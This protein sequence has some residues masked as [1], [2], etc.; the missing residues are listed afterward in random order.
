[1]ILTSKLENLESGIPTE[2]L[3]VC[4]LSIKKKFKI[5][6]TSAKSGD[7]HLRLKSYEKSIRGQQ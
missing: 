1:M 4:F 7:P 2:F 5:D 3:R 6:L